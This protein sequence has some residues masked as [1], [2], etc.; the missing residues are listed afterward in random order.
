MRGT[1]VV[2]FD[3]IA[4]EAAGRGRRDREVRRRRRARFRTG[5]RSSA[6][7]RT[8]IPAFR[9]GARSRRLRCSPSYGRLERHSRRRRA[10]V[11]E[12]SRRRGA[13]GEPAPSIAMTR[14]CS[15]GSRR[16]EPT[17]RSPNRSRICVGRVRIHAR[18]RNCRSRRRIGSSRSACGRSWLATRVERLDALSDRADSRRTASA[19]SPTARRHSRATARPFARSAEGPHRRAGRRACALSRR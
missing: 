12:G 8:V 5:S 1:H 16:C 4:Q 15:G 2:C 7:A 3:R 9:V 17:C 6:T 10:M 18:S 19:A 11:G 13:R 14:C